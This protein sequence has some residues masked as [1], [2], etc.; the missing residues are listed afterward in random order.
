MPLFNRKTIQRHGAQVDSQPQ[1][2]K[3]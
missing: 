1:N 2:P 3:V